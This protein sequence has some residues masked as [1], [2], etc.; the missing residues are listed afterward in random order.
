[1]NLRK[2]SVLVLPLVFVFGCSKGK[3][4]ESPSGESKVECTNPLTSDDV[5]LDPDEVH[6]VVEEHYRLL[7]L[8][9]ERALDTNPTLQ[10]V[11]DV[12]VVVEADGTPSQVCSGHST[13]ADRAVVAC[14][15]RTFSAFRFPSQSGQV[16]SIYPVTFS[17]Y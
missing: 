1:M 2:I 13:L 9:Y 17:P 16:A 7:R 12:N 11:I 6:A 10:G 14:V 8:C 3:E 15:I 5:T 4:A